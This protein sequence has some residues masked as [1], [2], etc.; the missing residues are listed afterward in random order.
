MKELQK[1]FFAVLLTLV[2]SI[3]FVS[4]VFAE[5]STNTRNLGIEASASFLV[6]MNTGKVIYEDN[7][8]EAL[9]IASMT[10]MMS[11]YLIEEAIANGQLSWDQK[12]TVSNYAFRISQNTSLSNVPL[13]EGKEYTVKELFEAAVIFSANGATIAL[14]EAISGTEQNFVDK[15]NERG[16]ELGLENFRFVNSTGLNNESLMGMHPENTSATEENIASARDMAIL[17][18]RL[19][20]DFPET[21]ETSSIPRMNFRDGQDGETAMPNWNWMLPG[22]IFEYEGMQGLK[23]G[24][25]Q[26]A[27]S[28]FTG[29]AERDGVRLISVV[30]NTADRSARFVETRK[31]MDFGFNNFEVVEAF[32]A[33]HQE[34]GYETVATNGRP[35]QVEVATEDSLLVLVERGRTEDLEATY[36]ITVDEVEGPA[37]AGTVVGT[38]S[39]ENTTSDN[40]GFLL[41]TQGYVN[42]VTTEDVAQANI[43]VRGF[44]SIGSFF[45]NLVDT[46]TGLF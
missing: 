34:E 28:C 11:A 16:E 32:P 42:V 12:V 18:Y 23:T 33:G 25:T 13:L 10:K 3:S 38:M 24:S 26:A 30:L 14:A 43:F 15:M 20:T 31:L 6:E 4:P 41:P 2:F 36:N 1:K 27:G 44:R 39:V 5:E 17:A 21:L 9:P 19:V 7:A 45:G 29:L 35:G 22:L 46:I 40:L 8:D 37:E